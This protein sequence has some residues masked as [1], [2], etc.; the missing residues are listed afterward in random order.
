MDVAPPKKTSRL[1]RTAE[2]L[3]KG[4]LGI[5]VF[6]FGFPLALGMVLY[7]TFNLVDMFMISRLENATAALGALGVCDMVSTLATIVANGISNASVAII[8]RR[9][10][11]HDLT[12]IRRAT[13]QSL[14][15]IAALSVFFGLIGVFGSDFV[16]RTLMQ[17][18]GEAASL[19]VDYLEVMLGGSF[20]MLF[21]LQIS[22]IIRA[23]GHAKT[24]ATL[25]ITGNVLNV[26]LNIF[27]VF[28]PGPHP[29]FLA[30]AAPIAQG[31]GIPRLGVE[32][33]AWSTVIGRTIPVLIGAWIL[34]RRKGGPKFHPIYL[35]PNWPE[36]RALLTLGW[37]ASAQLLV[38]ILAILAIIS[39]INANYTTATDQHTLTAYSICLRLETMA[40]FIGLGWGAAASSF[41][42]MNLGA[43]Q[44]RRAK[45]AGWIAAGYNFVVM[46]L[47][48][49]LY[50]AES[51][52]I[53][54][55]FDASPDVLLIGHEY[56]VTVGLSYGFFGVGIVLSQAMS[57]AGAT[58]S[59]MFLD[60]GIL[61]LIAVPAFYV[62][63][64][65]AGLPRQALWWTI[66]ASNA[67]GCFA[68]IG[69][70]LRGTFL[71]KRLS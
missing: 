59:S 69:Y 50:T 66:A 47:L 45:N 38:R 67:I 20:S 12:G 68:F 18:K 43:G 37:P 48:L 24:A 34:M 17:T 58:L 39:L 40:L 71:E 10:G 42:G 7:T 3:T 56:L 31:L 41:V 27:L 6:A 61:M 54:G 65:V 5:G 30:W 55:F 28:G 4:P 64:E 26:I 33:S 53:I 22:S 14:L 63:T 52:A 16:V 19:G 15:V 36:L 13:Y 60:S 49:W 44:P 32:G 70:Y 2:R 11:A 57:G 9:A 21:L 51:E 62:V 35:R 25:L 23:I 46:L 1:A 8:S 29:D